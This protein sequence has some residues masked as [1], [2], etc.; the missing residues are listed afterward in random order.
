MSLLHIMCCLLLAGIGNASLA[1]F[2]SDCLRPGMILGWWLPWLARKAAPS[3]CPPLQ[4]ALEACQ[5]RREM[6]EVMV[7]WGLANVWW[8]KPVGGCVKCFTPY[9]SALTFAGLWAVT[10]VN[11]NV[12][13]AFG[14]Y[15]SFTVGALRL[16][17]RWS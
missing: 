10:D 15:L 5:T 11:L 16:L 13:L 4:A 2:I 3:D 17:L 8:L 12:W 9:L 6:D 1:L 7:E 14:L